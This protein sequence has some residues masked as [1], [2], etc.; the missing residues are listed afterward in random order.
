MA[1]RGRWIHLHTID[2]TNEYLKRNGEQ[3][4]D[5]TVVTASHQ[6]AGK[7]RQGKIWQDSAEQSFLGSWLFK[8]LSEEQLKLLPMA[9]G[10]AVYQ[11]LSQ[12]GLQP[13]WL[14]WPN[15]VVARSSNGFV[16]LSGILCESRFFDGEFWVVCGIGLNLTQTREQLVQG[17]LEQAGSVS[18]IWG[19]TLEPECF[20]QTLD[21]HLFELLGNPEIHAEQILE[22]YSQ[23]CITLGQEVIIEQNGRKIQAVA[24]QVEPDG[25][26]LCWTQTEYLRVHAGEVSVRGQSG[27]V[28]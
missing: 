15:D 4:P 23:V 3:L 27:Y 8:S 21:A 20:R 28:D 22:R 16:K 26:L 11:T 14:K 6:T 12:Q 17:G 10:L 13:I 5:W 1:E 18:S 2:S 9:A 19:K 24:Q 25:T 7:G